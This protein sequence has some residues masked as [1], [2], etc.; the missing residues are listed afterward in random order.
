M[1]YLSSLS[2]GVDNVG[3][4]NIVTDDLT[5]ISSR[6]F[7]RG[8][9]TEPPADKK[10]RK[11]S[12]KARVLTAFLCETELLEELA[13]LF[14]QIITVRVCVSRTGH[15]TTRKV[16]SH[17]TMRVCVTQGPSHDNEG[18]RVVSIKCHEYTS[19]EPSS[20][21]LVLLVITTMTSQKFQLSRF[22]SQC[23]AEGTAPVSFEQLRS[24]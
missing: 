4:V 20:L 15:H 16:P 23:F 8:S 19:N 7:E 17:I 11:D 10:E 12:T 13:V 21:P 24:P 1:F 2:P 3:Q 22:P 18:R 6:Y 5:A 14:C 9:S